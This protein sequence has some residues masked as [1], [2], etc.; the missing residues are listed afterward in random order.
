MTA[1][2]QQHSLF[3]EILDWML[4]PLLLLWPMSVALTWLVAQNI[5]NKP[6]DRELGEMTRVLAKQVVLLETVDGEA[7]ALLLKRELEPLGVTLTRI[8]SGVP[9]GGDLD[10]V[11]LNEGHVARRRMPKG[12]V[13][14][15]LCHRRHIHVPNEK[16]MSRSAP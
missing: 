16:P 6:F 11:F 13:A 3:G 15:F 5:A 9:H 14:R 1:P 8:A 12:I 7:T 2:S 4:A 10:F